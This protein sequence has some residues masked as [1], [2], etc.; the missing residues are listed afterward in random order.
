VRCTS[1]Q[2]AHS[3][4]RTGASHRLIGSSGT[5]RGR[6]GATVDNS[7]SERLLDVRNDMSLICCLGADA[8][9][10]AKRKGPATW[11]SPVATRRDS[12]N[13]AGSL[14]LASPRSGRA[15]NAYHA[16]Y[17][18]WMAW[19]SSKGVVEL[20]GGQVFCRPLQRHHAHQA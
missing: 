3:D 6:S 12:G 4:G 2:L 16:R 9:C 18:G 19:L 11:P 20:I 13:P 10:R 15:H 1:R 7:I 17:L 14:P 8:R 5:C